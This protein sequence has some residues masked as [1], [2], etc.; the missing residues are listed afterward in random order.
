MV[1]AIQEKEVEWKAINKKGKLELLLVST[2]R[3]YRNGDKSKQAFT[4]DHIK[5]ILVLA[6]GVQPDTVGK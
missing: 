6:F 3:M 2:I 1:K 4:K 5:Y